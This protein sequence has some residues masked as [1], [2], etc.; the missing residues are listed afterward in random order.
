MEQLDE[1]DRN[2]HLRKNNINNFVPHYESDD[3]VGTQHRKKI[4]KPR[5]VPSEKDKGRRKKGGQNKINEEDK[6]DR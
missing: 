5:I 4:K 2:G 3:E 6:N 1:S